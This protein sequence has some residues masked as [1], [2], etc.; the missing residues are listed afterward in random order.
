MG[1][2]LIGAAT[3]ASFISVFV[4]TWALR[5]G[6]RLVTAPLIAGAALALVAPVAAYV[7]RMFRPELV[8]IIAPAV[9]LAVFA[10]A[11]QARRRQT[12]EG[13]RP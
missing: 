8:F 1:R 11:F 5:R 9:A 3:L 13:G 4:V 10:A 6:R 12:T 2:D 7:T